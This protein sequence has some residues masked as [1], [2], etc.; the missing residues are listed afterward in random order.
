MKQYLSL[1]Q[2][3]KRSPYQTGTSV[4]GTASVTG[5]L[6]TEVKKGNEEMI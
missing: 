4:M 1:Y 3:L 2:L 6:V 5:E